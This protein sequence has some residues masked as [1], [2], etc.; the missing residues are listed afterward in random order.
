MPLSTAL[1]LTVTPDGATQTAAASVSGATAGRTVNLYR[2]RLVNFNAGTLAWTLA[3]S[4]V[5]NGGGVASITDNAGATGLFLWL[6]AQLD[7]GGTNAEALSGVAFNAIRD[8][9]ATSV[10][11]QC[12][13]HTADIINALLLPALP[14]AKIVERWFPGDFKGKSPEAPSVQVCPFG[15]EEYPGTLNNTDDVGYPVLVVAVSNADGESKV[16]FTR[17]LL[18][19]ERISRALR[20]QQPAGVGSVYYT[21]LRPEVLV[22]PDEWDKGLLLSALLFVYRSRETRGIS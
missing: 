10:W 20:F 15:A 7:A 4:G 1:T 16:D 9:S 11:E 12:V 2:R 3:G 18:W 14:A 19:R 21:D 13:D 22:L 5:A 8:P 17:N 6:A